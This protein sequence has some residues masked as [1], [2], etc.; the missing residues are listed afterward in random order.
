MRN[1][2]TF[3]PAIVAIALVTAAATAKTSVV[4][5]SVDIAVV[6]RSTT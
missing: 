1:R 2:F 3:R 4:A 5:V 6:R